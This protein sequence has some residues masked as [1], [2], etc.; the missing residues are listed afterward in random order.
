MNLT[1]KELLQHLGAGKS[2]NDLCR[3][4]GITRD[5]FDAWWKSETG[6]RVPRHSGT[7]SAAVSAGVSIERDPWSIPH[8]FAANDEDLFFG[9]GYAMAQDRLFQLD[10]LRRKSHGRLSEILGA[11]GL[12]LD[13]IARTVGF[14]R[15][16]A[17]EWQQAGPEARTLVERFSA[18][19]NAFIDETASS[20]PLEFDLLDYKPEPWSPVDCYAIATELGYYLTVRF[21]IIC[22]PEI[23]RRALGEGPLFEAFLQGEADEESILPPGSYPKS[24]SGTEPI[25]HTISDPNEGQ[26]SNNWVLSGKRTASGKPLIASDPH[27]AFAAVSCWYEVHLSGGSFDV[28]GMAYPGVPAVIFGANRRVGWAITNNICSQRDLYQEKTDNEHSGDFLYDGKWEPAREITETIKVRDAEPV[29]KRITFSRNGPIVDELLPPAARQTGPV[30]LRWLG[31]DNSGWLESLLA[32]D[33]ARSCDEFREALRP[34]VVPTWSLLFADADGHI[35]YQAVGRIPLRNDWKRGYL[36]GWNPA[37]QWQGLTPFEGMPQW[38]DPERGWIA[39]ANNRPASDDFPYPLA[40]CWS[41]GHRAL[42]IRQMIEERDGLTAGD[43]AE[44]HQDAKSLRAVEC[45]PHLVNALAAAANADIKRAVEYLIDWNGEML[46][47]SVAATLFEVFFAQ[48]SRRVA[49]ERFDGAAAEFLENSAGGLASA[50]LVDDSAGWF[51]RSNRLDAIREAFQATLDELSDRLGSDIDSWQWGR[52]HKIQ[53]RHVLSA[54]GDLGELLDRGNIP[55]RGNG[56]TVCN[57]G[58]DPNWGAP[59]GANYRLIT[60]FSTSPP[61]FQAV[62]AQGQSGHPGSKHYCDQLNEWINGRYHPMEF[63]REKLQARAT[64]E[65]SPG[66]P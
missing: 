24:Q 42:R 32:L 48:W 64:L 44:M 61:T 33:R 55:V 21:G 66:A 7:L 30:S 9:F 4:A 41:S 46:P 18:G 39:S 19:I 40:G 34:W 12:E 14:G 13:T 20:L 53:L 11:D 26:G 3:Q 17:A 10:Y 62:D 38:S 52:L 54:R 57:T 27:I 31:T 56:I 15:I 45:L 2:I 1:T 65:L 51:H 60:D 28:V 23:A 63:E 59:M 35:G 47:E 22:G 29:T 8:I 58:F 6:S 37:H 25:G 36:E 43:C 50:L 16:A 49:R 5:D